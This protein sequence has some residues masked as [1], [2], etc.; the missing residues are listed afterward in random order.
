LKR[1]LK[2]GGFTVTVD[3]RFP[4]V[5]RQCAA[6]PRK[7]QQGTWITDAF[8]DAYIRLH[9]LDRAHSV[10][11][12]I[13]GELAGGLYGVAVGKVFCGESMFSLRPDAS[14]IALVHLVALLRQLRFPL[15]DCQMANPYLLSM[16][17]EEMDRKT[18]L[19][20]LRHLAS[21]K[22]TAERWR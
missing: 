9:E 16:G 19:G 11:V 2:K 13:D 6:V 8:I 10:E 17:A 1:R 22:A 14:K 21:Q 20:A 15:I 4:D 18:F 5:I 12:V 3:Q 7:G